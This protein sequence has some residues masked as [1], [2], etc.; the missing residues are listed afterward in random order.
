MGYAHEEKT[1][2]LRKDSNLQPLESHSSA[3]TNWATQANSRGGIRTHNARFNRPLRHHFASRLSILSTFLP[4][5]AS[6]RT[7]VRI[8]AM[9]KR[10]PKKRTNAFWQVTREELVRRLESSDSMAAVIRGFGLSG[11]GSNHVTLKNRLKSED[12]DL[13]S[14]KKKWL[15]VKKVQTR[16]LSK[17]RSKPLEYYL[18]EGNSSTSSY[19]LKRKLITAGVLPNEC[20]VCGL[21]EWMGKPLVLDIH[22][23][24]GISTDNRLENLSLLCPNCH[25][26]TENFAGKNKKS[27]KTRT[28]RRANAPRPERRK[29]ERPSAEELTELLKNHSWVALGKR[30]GVSDNAIRKWAKSYGL[31]PLSPPK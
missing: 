2:C 5:K 4:F 14:Y 30:F 13:E 3:S 6:S 29:V 10:I 17:S 26:Q 19:H 23:A 9:T 24:N 21:T 25:R 11:H 28:P 27:F 12:I 22:H 1:H 18:V 8:K 20:Q 7:Y 15:E 31:L 16:E